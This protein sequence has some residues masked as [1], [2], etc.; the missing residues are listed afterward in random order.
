M[1]IS[2]REFI[3]SGLG[4][5]SLCWTRPEMLVMAA[6]AAESPRQLGKS[7]ILVL[8]QL[9]GG[10]DGLNTVIPY[11][12]GAYYDAR[13]TLAIAQE[14]V[15][16]LD[17]KVGLNPSMTGIV[18]LYRRGKV[19]VVQAVGYPNPNRSHFRSMEIWQTAQP[20][21]IADYGWL[22]NYLDHACSD[23]SDTIFAAINTDATLPRSLLAR[24]VSVPSVNNVYDFRFK[25]D[26]RYLEDRQTQVSTFNDIYRDYSSQRPHAELLRKVGMDARNASE[27]LLKVVRSYKGSVQYPN[28][29]FA[30]SLKFVS[31]MIC[32]GVS[33]KVY[34]VSL[35][36]FDTHTNQSRTQA[37]LLKKLS[38]GLAAFQS[39]L[40]AHGV[41]SD[42]VTLV[43]SEFGRRVA[44]N[45]GKGTDH[46]TAAPV[47]V[48]GSRVKS[49]IY[50]DHPDLG[51]LDDGDLRY[52]IDFRTI[53]ASILDRW[54]N[55]DSRQ[56][57]G[58]HFGSLPI[59]A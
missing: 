19:A 35:D 33:A 43:F 28:S 41:D 54:M 13:P 20:D 57:L 34:N 6:Q 53:Y 9:S 39:D 52:K 37:G 32:G 55:A 16:R 49:G 14:K 24:R 8:V 27:H 38:E 3:S 5:L 36:G 42:V 40:E 44:E 2:R 58:G 4:L 50:S 48:I 46:G 56:V 12:N 17:G 11:F 25:T 1:G 22:G 59:F 26:P 45:G 31:Q 30:E 10:N 21:K 51:R 29:E 15:L 47:L 23:K 7:K 18:D